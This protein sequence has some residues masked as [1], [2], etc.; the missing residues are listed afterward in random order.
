MVAPKSQAG[1]L[2]FALGLGVLI[3]LLAFVY[4]PTFKWLVTEIWWLDKEYSHGFL[5]PFI[6]AYLIWIRRGYLA[7]LP[8]RP[9]PVAGSLVLLFSAGL[10]LGG[11]AGG[12]RQAEGFSFLFVLPGLV[13]FLWGWTHLKALALPLAYVQFMVP[14]MEDFIDRVHWPFQ[15]LSAEIGV[16]VLRVFGYPVFHTGKYITLPAITL[17]V[18]RECSGLR[19]LMSI[20]AL[21]IPLVYLTQRSWKRAITVILSAIA[22]AIIANGLRVALVGMSAT[23]YGESMLHGPW[24]VFQGWF[25][26][27]V[28]IVVL[29]IFNWLATRK[30][31]DDRPRLYERAARRA[32][33]RSEPWFR[34]LM[35]AVVFLVVF[36]SWLNYYAVS[37]PVPLKRS[38]TYF[39]AEIGGWRGGAV[40]WFAGEDA[41]PGTASE[42]SR[43][44]RNAEGKA[45]YL[46]VGYFDAQRPGKAMING[47]ANNPLRGSATQLSFKVDAATRDAIG[48]S[49][50]NVSIPILGDTPYAAVYWYRFPSGAVKGR[51]QAKLTGLMNAVL[52]RHDN[53]AVIVIAEP[54]P[55]DVASEAAVADLL[56]F[57]RAATPVVRDYI[58]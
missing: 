31:G 34:H 39:P 36:G 53:A 4:Y 38:F 41:Y 40:H 21:G 13:L 56:A 58:P 29:F 50:V 12:F 24:H 37:V 8:T 44:Y 11:R 6:V 22:I 28:G 45:V 54:L 57:A 42:L 9:A 43:V 14:W 7:S 20:I 55:R 51:Y 5:V 47:R 17:E 48:L 25:V 1:K 49:D 2:Q 33:G 35:V 52:H 46:Y 18:A 10:L 16:G 26:S 32:D 3:A 30:K 15:L 19:F 23:R 27:Q